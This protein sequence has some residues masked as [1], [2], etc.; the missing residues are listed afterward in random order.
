MA[1]NGHTELIIKKSR[2][3]AEIARIEDEAAAQ[4]FIN[5]I[6]KKYAKA[7]HHC[8]AYQLGFNQEIQRMSDDG[9]PSGTAGSPIL[10]VLEKQNLVNVICVVTRYF[11]GIKLGAGG[12]IRA[13]G[14]A[15][16]AAVE[17][18]GKVAGI[19]QDQYEITIQY[20]RLDILTHWLTEQQIN[21][22]DTRYTDKVS[23]NIWLDQDRVQETLTAMTNLLADQL[24]LKKISSGFN[25]VPIA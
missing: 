14:S 21:I 19:A 2:F 1:Q 24:E 18:V 13:Y 5:T 17:T 23:L 6:K 20:N 4:D 9:E 22:F 10:E 7:T 3:I 15:T 8:Y 12:L 11:G 25:E 16:A